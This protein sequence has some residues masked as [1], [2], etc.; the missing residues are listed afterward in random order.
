MSGRRLI[1]SADDFGLTA[2]VDR[3]ILAAVAAGSVTSVGVM[4]NL[5]DPA[6]LAALAAARAGVSIGVHLNLTTGRPLCAPDEVPSLVDASGGFRSLASLARHALTGRIRA[7]EVARELRVQIARVRSLGV[8][9]DHLDSHEHVHLLPGVIGAVVSLAREVG[10]G[11]MRTHRPLLLDPAGRGWRA[12]LAYY[13]RYPR[14]VLTHGAKRVFARVIA[15]AGVATPDAMVATSLLAHPVSGG[16]LAEWEALAAALPPGT[17]ELVVHPANLA[18]PAGKGDAERL[19]DLVARRADEL[20]ALV[21]PR[22]REMLSTHRVALV[23]FS[24]IGAR[25][26]R[27]ATGEGRYV[28]RRA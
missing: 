11:R 3:G 23:P 9:V 8:Q 24:A 1:V 7:A 14:R 10:G 6:A 28:A 5:V 20:R 18:V 25:A 27:R 2:G 15:L 16:P 22:F 26:P 13:R 19:G 12:A 21:S 4:G 17:W